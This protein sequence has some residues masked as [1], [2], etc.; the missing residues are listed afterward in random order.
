M[1]KIKDNF[2]L[3]LWVGGSH[4]PCTYLVSLRNCPAFQGIWYWDWN[5]PAVFLPVTRVF[6]ISCRFCWLFGCL[7]Y[8]DRS[9]GFSRTRGTGDRRQGH[10]RPLSFQSSRHLQTVLR[11]TLCTV[12]LNCGS[13]VNVTNLPQPRSA[14]ITPQSVVL[15]C[16]LSVEQLG[17]KCRGSVT[18][19]ND[20][21][22]EPASNWG[23]PL[24]LIYGVLFSEATPLL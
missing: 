16:V 5:I 14:E 10:V 12:I 8:A 13:S 17:R 24:L 19:Q 21:E 18:T 2:V 11:H 6:R 23:R 4:Y 9:L 22:N 15:W 3:S 20:N 7:G 1:K